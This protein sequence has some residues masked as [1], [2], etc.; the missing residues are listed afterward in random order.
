MCQGETCVPDAALDGVRCL[1]SGTSCGYC[2]GGQCAASVVPPCP[3]GSCPQ[4]GQCCPGD[5]RCVEPESPTGYSCIW[6]DGCCPDQRKCAGGCVYKQ[7]CCPEERP[8]CG[9]CGDICVNGTWRCSALKPCA[10]GS[11]LAPDECCPEQWTCADGSCVAQDECCP[12]ERRCPDGACVSEGACC[13]GEKLCAGGDCVAQNECC[14][15]E[16]PPVCGNCE[17]AACE[18]GNWR[19]RPS[20]GGTCQDSCCP[21]GY[22]CHHLGSCCRDNPFHCTCPDGYVGCSGWCCK[23]CC[24][25]SCCP[26]G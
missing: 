5:K 14:P 12:D 8:T 22:Y 6:E 9:Q 7:T 2:Q 21:E 19:C 1:G 16:S 15:S 11:C 4:H 3:D 26:G 23:S 13:P 24:G 25:G 20:G 10:D 18:N 17:V